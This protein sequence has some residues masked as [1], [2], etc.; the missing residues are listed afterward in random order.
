MTATDLIAAHGSPLWLADADQVRANVRA[1]RGAL[2]RHWP[3]TRLAYS[4][5]T[6]RLPAFLRA[7]DDE[8][9]APEVVCGA[10]YLLAREVV[11]AAGGGLWRVA[12]PRETL[13]D[14]LPSARAV[15]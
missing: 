13:E 5:K 15:A 2:A 14:L 9:V 3:A 4:Y 6:N 12:H 8:G 7:V 10:E 11:E 1:L